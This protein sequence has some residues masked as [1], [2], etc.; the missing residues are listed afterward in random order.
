MANESQDIY[1]EVKIA[2]KS[3]QRV[4]ANIASVAEVTI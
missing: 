1:K 2:I 4:A 3:T